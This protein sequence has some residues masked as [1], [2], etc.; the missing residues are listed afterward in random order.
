MRLYEFAKKERFKKKLPDEIEEYYFLDQSAMR[1]T[2]LPE[3]GS[4]ETA[5][6]YREKSS[7]YIYKII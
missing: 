4:F 5:K 6:T 1:L 2:V 3:A 7:T